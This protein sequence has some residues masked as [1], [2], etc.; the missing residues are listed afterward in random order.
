MESIVWI[1]RT[2]TGDSAVYTLIAR[3]ETTT[4]LVESISYPMVPRA[5]FIM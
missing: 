3:W 1:E 5:E 4:S 2:H